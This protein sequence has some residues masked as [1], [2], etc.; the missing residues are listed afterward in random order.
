MNNYAQSYKDI[1]ANKEL[2]CIEITTIMG[3]AKGNGRAS[4]LALEVSK[5]FPKKHERSGSGIR[6]GCERGEH[7]NA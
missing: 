7:G 4:N 6:P 3:E 1:K 2:Q 5:G